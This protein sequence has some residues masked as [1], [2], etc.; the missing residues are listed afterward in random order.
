MRRLGPLC[1][2]DPAHGPVVPVVN[3]RW[4]WYCPHQAH[5]GLRGKPSTRAYFTTVEVDS[6]IRR[7]DPVVDKAV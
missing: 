2:V 1:P 5:D 4:G 3:S 7:F 6:G